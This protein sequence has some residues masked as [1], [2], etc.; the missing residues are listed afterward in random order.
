[1]SE[2]QVKIHFKKIKNEQVKMNALQ[3]SFIRWTLPFLP[4][5]M[6]LV[7]IRWMKEKVVRWFTSTLIL[8]FNVD[9]IAREEKEDRHLGLW[10]CCLLGLESLKGVV[11]GL[12]IL[13]RWNFWL[14]R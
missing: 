4:S 13:M 6:L 9:G 1:M 5:L 7:F 2:E 11:G 8:K 12:R 3:Q 14:L 10:E